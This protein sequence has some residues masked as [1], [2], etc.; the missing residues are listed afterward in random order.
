MRNI[1]DLLARILI[2]SV[3]IYE[4]IDSLIFF[5]NVKDQMTEFGITWQ[6]D[7]LLVGSL[8]VLS[9]GGILLLIGYRMGLG[10]TLVLAYW[11]PVTFIA[12]A[13]WFAPQNEW[14][15]GAMFFARNLAIAGGVIALMLKGSDKYSVKRLMK[16]IR[17]P[18][19]ET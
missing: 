7:I 15:W 14:R 12:H 6:Q 5:D 18:K 13:F 3:F 1:A 2:S 4:A 16:V 19:G 8:L 9:I 17:I 11:V 10:G